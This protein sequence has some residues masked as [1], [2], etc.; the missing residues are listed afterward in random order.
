MS[1]HRDTQM[2]V[3]Y[4]AEGQAERASTQY[5]EGLTILGD[6]KIEPEEVLRARYRNCYGTD[7][8]GCHRDSIKSR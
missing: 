3:E 2:E 1:M 5:V 6:V 8:A 4:S 7:I